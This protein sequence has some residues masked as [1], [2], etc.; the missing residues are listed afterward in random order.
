VLSPE[1]VVQRIRTYASLLVH[2]D[3]ADDARAKTEE[4]KR[5][6]DGVVA[7]RT[8]QDTHGRCQAQ[9]VLLHVPANAPE[10][11]V[12]GG[13]E[14]GEVGHLSAGDEPDRDVSGKA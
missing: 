6:V 4:P 3:R 9:P 14:G 8:G 10:D 5:P 13:G 7:F 12:A 1:R 11:V 2:R